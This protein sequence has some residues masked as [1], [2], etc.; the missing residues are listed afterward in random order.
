MQQS[1]KQAHAGAPGLSSTSTF[2]PLLPLSEA[3][4]TPDQLEA[5]ASRLTRAGLGNW[6][7]V[8][9]ASIRYSTPA[10]RWLWNEL[11]NRLDVAPERIGEALVEAGILSPADLVTLR[12]CATSRNLEVAHAEQIRSEVVEVLSRA[13][14]I[15]SER[16]GHHAYA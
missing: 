6:T 9:V 16:G 1:S 14:A 15:Y 4:R 13:L 2:G 3:L 12:R 7:P 10:G 8:D 5:I 11:A